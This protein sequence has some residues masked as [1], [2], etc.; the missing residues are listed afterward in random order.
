MDVF[1]NIYQQQ[2]DKVNRDW[3]SSNN[4]RITN[5]EKKLD[6]EDGIDYIGYIPIDKN[7]TLKIYIDMKNTNDLYFLNMF[8][9]TFF[10]RHPFKTK[11]KTTHYFFVRTLSLNPVQEHLEIV[12]GDKESFFAFLESIDGQSIEGMMNILNC[13]SEEQLC[14]KIKKILLPFLKDGYDIKYLYDKY[15]TR[16][17]KTSFKIY[18]R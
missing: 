8:R 17:K 6:M 2:S 9:G 5:T 11:S 12:I 1:N 14:L 18:E 16:F 10:V 7:K 4:Y 15:D 3:F 13:S